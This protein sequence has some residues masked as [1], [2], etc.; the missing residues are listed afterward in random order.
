[1]RKRY[2][3]T[4]LFGAGL[5]LTACNTDR[6]VPD[7]P[8]NG[9]ICIG[10]ERDAGTNTNDPCRNIVCNTPPTQCHQPTG[11]C[12]EGQCSYELA[13]GQSC[14]DGNACTEADLCAADGACAGTPLVCATPPAP[15]CVDGD[16]SRV[17]NPQGTCSMGSCNYI[18][19]DVSCPGM[20]G[21]VNPGLC[22]DP[23]ANRVCD[24]PPTPCYAVP[25]TCD[26][27]TG[28]CTYSVDGSITACDDGDACTMNDAC[29]GDGTCFGMGVV[30]DQPPA[31]TC[32]DAT[33]LRTFTVNGAMCNPGTSGCDYPSVDM[34]CGAPGCSNGAC[35]TTCDETTCSPWRLPATANGT[36]VRTCG[37]ATCPMTVTLPALDENR[38]RCHVQPILEA[39]CAYLGCHTT[40]T[41]TRRLQTFAVNLKRMGPMLSGK[42]HDGPVNPSYC[43]GTD[44]VVEANCIADPLTLAEW[45][46][47]YDNARLFALDAAAP[48]NNEL[49]T[50]PLAGDPRGHVHDNFDIF[51][52]TNDVRYQAILAWLNGATSTANCNG[53]PLPAT[54][55]RT[56]LGINTNEGQCPMCRQAGT[57]QCIPPPN[58][59]YPCDPNACVR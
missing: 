13:P 37:D 29:Q 50:Q 42:D 45:T 9:G 35:N 39:G 51:A 48:V 17:F 22:P 43:N 25:G 6:D 24:A 28:A 11:T 7:G 54:P 34:N 46:F 4:L 52:S 27:T 32:I 5:L 19:Q 20:C 49:L 26:D 14:N 40:D 18:S 44:S 57:G 12:D 15:T 56:A 8:C 58:P 53:L 3:L 21:A 30:C 38:F 2:S 36:A 55:G 23:C 31:P 41:P 33:T 10:D 16:T 47:N 1:M 59:T